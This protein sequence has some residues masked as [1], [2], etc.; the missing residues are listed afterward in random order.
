MSTIALPDEF[1]SDVE[2]LWDYN[3]MHHEVRPVDVGIGLGSHD[4]GVATYAAELYHRGVFPLIVF[5]GA[6]SP[7][8]AEVFPH[9]EAAH[10]R[11]H[12]LALGVP[13]SAILM[14]SRATNTGDNI[15]FTRAL[16]EARGFLNSIKSVMLISRPYQQRRGYATCRVRWAGG[17]RHLWIASAHIERLP[18]L[19]RGYESRGQH[20]GG[21]HSTGMG[22]RRPGMGYR[23]GRSQ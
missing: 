5:T 21:R 3:Q 22:L 2:I 12:A 23:A 1:R 13:D 17:R 18:R 8:T 14:E 6:N 20:A 19:H 9:G 4:L 10:Y 16:L 7:T 11:G 15:D